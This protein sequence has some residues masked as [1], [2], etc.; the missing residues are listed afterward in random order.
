MDWIQSLPAKFKDN[1]AQVFPITNGRVPLI[2]IVLFDQSQW[3]IKQKLTTAEIEWYQQVSGLLESKDVIPNVAF[4]CPSA[5]LAVFEYVQGDSP[6]LS[7]LLQQQ[8]SFIASLSRCHYG[9]INT[10]LE[11]IQVS[12]FELVTKVLT[13]K[14][15]PVQLTTKCQ[16]AADELAQLPTHTAQLHGDLWPENILLR[17]AAFMFVDWEFHFVG[18]C[19]WDLAA[20]ATEFQMSPEQFEKL[21]TCY[22]VHNEIHDTSFLYGARLWQTVYQAVC[23]QWMEENKD[24]GLDKTSAFYWS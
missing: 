21:V 16:Q 10:K 18:D 1:L 13:D 6:N 23:Y 11:E 12:V 14:R 5:K 24:H 20:V 19:R 22:Q 15:M 4:L 8:I 2:R 9:L 3:V 17:D 7:Q